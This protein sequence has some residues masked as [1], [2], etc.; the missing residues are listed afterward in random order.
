M[1]EAD[2]KFS[3][4]CIILF[5]MKYVLYHKASVVVT[6]HGRGQVDLDFH[7]PL[8]FDEL[9]ENRVPSQRGAE[10]AE[11]A[12]LVTLHSTHVTQGDTKQ[13]QRDGR[14]QMAS[15]IAL[16]KAVTRRRQQ[17]LQGSW[18]ASQGCIIPI[19]WYW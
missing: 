12:K 5:R 7:V 4:T 16:I 10:A 14:P 9:R 1:N 15:P 19:K 6:D 18:Y 2:A 3:S 17:P 8:W 13:S 11:R